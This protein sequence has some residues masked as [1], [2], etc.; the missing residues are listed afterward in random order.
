MYYLNAHNVPPPLL[1][2]IVSST[3]H[4]LELRPPLFQTHI[5]HHL[6]TMQYIPDLAPFN[7]YL[8]AL[9][10]ALVMTLACL[11]GVLCSRYRFGRDQDDD[12]GFDVVHV[13]VAWRGSNTEYGTTVRVQD[14]EVGYI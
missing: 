8:A 14:V 9:A 5:P 12:D 13:R 1:E 4:H 10:V 11:V 7:A 6:P 3:K 2:H